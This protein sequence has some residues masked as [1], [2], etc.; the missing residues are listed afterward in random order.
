[1]PFLHKGLQGGSMRLHRIRHALVAVFIL[2]AFLAQATGTLAATTTGIL[3]GQVTNAQTNQPVAGVKVTATSPSATETVTTDSTGHFTFLDLPPDTYLVSTEQKGFEPLSVSGVT[4]NANTTRQM[5]LAMTPALRVI[6]RVTSRAAT[7]LVKPGTTADT[8]SI[9]PAQQA[10]A[11]PLGGGGLANSAWSALTSVP[12]VA[13][14]PGMAGYVGVSIR[15]GDYNQIGYEIDGVPV[16]R[17]FDLYPSSTIPALGQQ[18]LQVFTGAAPANAEAQGLSGYFNQVIRTGT[19]PGFGELEGDLGT[20]AFY[21]KA[22]FETGGASPNRNFSYYLGIGGYNEAPRV[23]DNYNGQSLTN[24]WGIP[25]GLCNP[26]LTI[27]VAPSCYVGGVYAGNTQAFGPGWTPLSG[28]YGGLNVAGVLCPTASGTCGALIYEPFNMFSQN[29]IMDRNNV[30]NVHFGIPHKDGTK[31]DIQLLGIVDHANTNYY[32]AQ[33]DQGGVTTL[34]AQG[35]GP[36][37]Y[38]SGYAY[39]GTLGAAL[40]ANYQALTVQTPFPWQQ[41]VG[42]GGP[43]PVTQPDGFLNDQMIYK[44]QW[45]HPFGENALM[46]LYGYTYY[47][48]WPNYGPNSASMFDG[49]INSDYELE[50]HTRGVSGSFIDQITPEHL[51]TLEGSY[52]T[53]TV[54]RNNNTGMFQGATKPFAWLTDGTLDG[55]CYTAAGAPTTCRS[56]GGAATVT[57]GTMFAG[58]VPAVPA[59]T[60]T[61]PK[62]VAHACQW[63]ALA[64]GLSAT[65]NNVTPQFTSFALTDQWRPTSKITVDA[66]LRYDQFGYVLP[67]QAALGGPARAF[68]YA[69]YN[70]DTC[71]NASFNSS[72]IVNVFGL[73]PGAPCP[74]GFTNAN[75]TDVNS[76]VTQT[77]SFW[78][79]RIGLTYSLNPDTVVRASYGRYT[80]AQLSAYQQYTAL[81]ANTPGLLYDTYGFQ[82]YGFFTDNHMVSPSTS[83]NLDLSLEHSFPNQWAVKVSPFYRVTQNQTQSFF[84][85]PITLF[86]SG[87]NVGAQT[88][89]GVE[90]EV[91]KGNFANDG[92]SAKLSFTY[93]NSYVKYATLPNGT[94]VLTPLNNAIQGFN[95]YTKD[96]APGGRLAGS[97]GANGVC[98]G[99]TATGQ[100]AAQCYTPAGVADNTCAAGDIANPYWNASAQP[101]LSLNQNYAPYDLFPAGIGVVAGVGSAYNVPYV[102]TFIAQYKHK[103]FAITPALQFLGGVRY[104]TPTNTTGIAPDTCAGILPGAVA[105]DPRYAN[106]GAPPAGGSPYDVNTCTGNLVAAP[107]PYTKGFDNIGQYVAPSQF[108]LHLQL[109]YQASPNVTLIATA[110]NLIDTC[111]GGSKTPWNITGACGYGT[112]DSGLVGIAGDLGVAGQTGITPGPG[113]GGL[114]NPGAGPIQSAMTNPYEPA[115]NVQPIELFV[116]ARVK[117]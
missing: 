67:N 23:V 7:D 47:S 80:A 69:A 17:A 21:H 76:T 64:N 117:I 78:Q 32:S 96:C 93:T 90:F 95:A 105:G 99:A 43:I 56:G 59:A 9:N 106:Y 5:P 108:L 92:L 50:S 103:R 101:L 72:D 52:T 8:Y 38:A 104:G 94:S 27:A 13:V 39:N 83:D 54:V 116:G 51:L 98:G 84:L 30:L 113:A 110:A 111:F 55:I 53:A 79:P 33:V 62:G 85:N 31:D 57:A 20:P 112:I 15:G 25:E 16:N 2:V 36:L 42:I 75:V 71:W 48:D 82:T 44:L 66:G 19:Y 115:F 45:T 77:Y 40:P 4:I 46:R 89:E 22:T 65:Y 41:Q 14:T 29:T 74:A 26:G 28:A 73:A 10:A 58:A 68:W 100:P 86:V 6:G 114:Y 109:S 12:G 102:A 1:M 70:A 91:D 49:F 24:E 107:N 60:C 61:D 63:T 87:L 3:T 81:Q 34:A 35:I 88:S 11:A 37:S 97:V 18:E